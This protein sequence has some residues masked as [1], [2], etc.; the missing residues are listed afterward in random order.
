MY[1]PQNNFFFYLF[2]ED[3]STESIK[4]KYSVSF[5]FIFANQNIKARRQH[6][7]KYQKAKKKS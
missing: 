7:S 1:V 5:C 2:G 3:P 4:V 6:I